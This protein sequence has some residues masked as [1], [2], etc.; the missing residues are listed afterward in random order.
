MDNIPDATESR[1]RC[2]FEQRQ[3]VHF[4]NLPGHEQ[5][6]DLQA[7]SEVQTVKILLR[8]GKEAGAAPAGQPA[9]VWL[10]RGGGEREVIYQVHHTY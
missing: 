8:G 1:E 7:G 4:S 9:G 3:F 6:P 10:D 5:D 2:R